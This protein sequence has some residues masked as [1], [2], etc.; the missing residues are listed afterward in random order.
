MTE[1]TSPNLPHQFQKGQSGNPA[2]KP[3]GARHKTTLLAERL[4]QDDAERIVNAV[5]TAA[6]NGEM[7]AAKII[8]DRICP[9]RR[10]PPFHLPA[11]ER[12]E[13]SL[14]AKQAVMAAV[15]GGDLTPS[16]A[17]DVFRLI[18]SA[19]LGLPVS[20]DDARAAYFGAAAASDCANRGVEGEVTFH[21]GG[22]VVTNEGTRN[23]N[24]R[25]EGQR[26]LE[27][28][29]LLGGERCAAR[30]LLEAERG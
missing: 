7:T 6:C 27:G 28:F 21:P 4:M 1:N 8:L 12:D 29:C 10:S 2:G 14:A 20:A 3:K 5:I 25:S 16:D 22:Q 24:A 9:P 18:E 26:P 17:V 15:A 23:Y 11:I 19:A 13:D 30:P